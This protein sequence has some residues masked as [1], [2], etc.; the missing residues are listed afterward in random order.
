[1][2]ADELMDDDLFADLYVYRFCIILVKSRYLVLTVVA[3]EVMVRR[4]R[5][6]RGLQLSQQNN[7]K[8]FPCPILRLHPPSSM[9]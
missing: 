6:L 2:E 1:M 8:Q 7:N 3:F 4:R 9:R 5:R